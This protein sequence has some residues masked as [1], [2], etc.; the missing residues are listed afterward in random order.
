MWCWILRPLQRGQLPRRILFVFKGDLSG[1]L[2]G[3]Q[4]TRHLQAWCW[5]LSRKI[6]AL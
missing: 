1:I 5:L 6:G 3:W 2:F 4:A